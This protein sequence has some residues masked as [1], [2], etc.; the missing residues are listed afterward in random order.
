MKES[1]QSEDIGMWSKIDPMEYDKDRGL[2]L[3][4]DTHQTAFI[5]TFMKKQKFW[6][7]SDISPPYRDKAELMAFA[8]WQSFINRGLSQQ[9]VKESY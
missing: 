9:S 5:F 1:T 2:L 4:Y 8:T 7:L 3:K 6:H